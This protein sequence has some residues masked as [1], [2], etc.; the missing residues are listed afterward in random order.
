MKVIIFRR[1]SS[2]VAGVLGTQID[3]RGH[4]AA[5]AETTGCGLA[6]HRAFDL[7]PR[8]RLGS[9]VWCRARRRCPLS[10]LSRRLSAQRPFVTSIANQFA[11]EQ[12]HVTANCLPGI[13]LY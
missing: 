9:A 5:R 3:N 13:L 7:R 1:F 2:L 10:A 11:A 6:S 12:R 8:Y 4:I